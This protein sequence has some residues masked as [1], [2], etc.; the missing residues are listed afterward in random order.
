MLT[1]RQKLILKAVIEE[2]IREAEP[3]SSKAL[4][5]KRGVAVGAPMLRKEMNS[6][7]EGGYL[8]KPHTS[9]GR[10][11]TDKAYRMYIQEELANKSYMT[12]KVN[13]P[14]VV[15]L[16]AKE[17]ERVAQ[18]LNKKWSDDQAL[19][20]EISRLVSEISKELSVAGTVGGENSYTFGF[21]NL[22]REPEF[23]TFGNINQL[24]RFMDNVDGYFDDLWSRVLNEGLNVFIGAENPIKEINE[25]TLITG[26]YQLPEGEQG[27]VSIIGPRRM[28]YKRNMSLVKYISEHINNINA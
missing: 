17:S 9:A 10:V 23:Q 25:F 7:E 2:Y 12:N 8:L 13:G 26:K 27:F 1:D 5:G 6:L 15:G 4:A 14:V 16:T 18:T 11:P 24:M 19:L 28:N 22:Y 20:K 21:S 3:V